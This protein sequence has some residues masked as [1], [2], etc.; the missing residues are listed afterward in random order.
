MMPMISDEC[1]DAVNAVSDPSTAPAFPS[2]VFSAQK[3]W[4]GSQKKSLSV[5]VPED[6]PLAV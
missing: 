4:R 1:N 6:D 3:R 2:D 5:Q